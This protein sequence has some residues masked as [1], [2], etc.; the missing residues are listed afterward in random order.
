MWA[1]QLVFGS[2]ADVLT[3][4]KPIRAKLPGLQAGFPG[5]GDAED[6]GMNNIGGQAAKLEASLLQHTTGRSHERKENGESMSDRDTESESPANVVSGRGFEAEESDSSYQSDEESDE[7]A[8]RGLEGSGATSGTLPQVDLANAEYAAK[9]SSGAPVPLVPHL[10]TMSMLPRTQWLNLVHLET[11]KER[12][13]PVEPPSKPDAAPFFLPTLSHANA[14][15][16]VIF[17]DLKDG[18]GEGEGDKGDK[19][20][21]LGSSHFGAGGKL[22][23]GESKFIKLLRQCSLAGDWTSLIALLRDMS[24][25]EIDQEIRYLQPTVFAA[26][27]DILLFLQFIESETASSTNFEFIQAILSST[28]SIL[29]ETLAENP[30]L[31]QAA[32][33]IEQRV[34]ASW[35]RLDSTLQHV[36]CMIGLLGGLQ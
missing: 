15:R 7:S 3:S 10:I 19:I 13:K 4:E 21:V 26:D 20:M 32:A 8:R 1:N 17:D 12:N 36:R 31:R 11:I 25:V 18:E 6:V 23:G 28:L 27:D 2:S 14:G 24:P 29:G 33:R 35:K 16:D 9:D 22:V 34:N 30:I 5:R